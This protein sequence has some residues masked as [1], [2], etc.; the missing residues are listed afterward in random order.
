[1]TIKNLKVRCVPVVKFNPIFDNL[2]S[3]TMTGFKYKITEFY[4]GGVL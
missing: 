4:R 3:N 1:M 2:A